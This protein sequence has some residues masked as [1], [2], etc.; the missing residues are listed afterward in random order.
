MIDVNAVVKTGATEDQ[1]VPSE[2]STFPEVPAV[3]GNVAV[4][5][6]QFVPSALRILPVP[7]AVAG[8]VAV[9]KAEAVPTP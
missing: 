7:V 8:Y 5:A 2:V 4:V 6:T 1:L 9:E 3:V